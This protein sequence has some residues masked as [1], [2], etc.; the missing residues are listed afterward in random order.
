MNAAASTTTSI[1]A[2]GSTSHAPAAANPIPIP[3]VTATSNA[4][5]RARAA[6]EIEQLR[7]RSTLKPGAGPMNANSR[8]GFSITSRSAFSMP[9]GS[10]ESYHRQ[11]P[12]SRNAA[13]RSALEAHDRA[14][15]G[16]ALRCGPPGVAVHDLECRLDPVRTALG[17]ERTREAGKKC[18]ACETAWA[19]G[20]RAGL[21]ARAQV[22]QKVPRARVGQRP[23]LRVHHRI[24][25][26]GAHEHVAD[27]VH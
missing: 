8:R 25:E 5:T 26:P 17:I 18:S 6:G 10:A 12:A 11:R 16:G 15:I 22:G 24:G 27:V 2:N 19:L 23:V 9:L 20:E 1:P 14:A 7:F 3:S 21:A 4:N 13:L